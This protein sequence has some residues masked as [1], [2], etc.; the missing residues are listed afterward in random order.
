MI[1]DLTGLANRA[2][3]LQAIDRAIAVTRR[4][5][6]T[7]SLLY[8]DLDRF[9]RLND[10]CGHDAGDAALR[11]VASALSATARRT[12][13]VGR[14]GGDDF[15]VV[16]SGPR[17]AAEAVARR[18]RERIVLRLAAQGWLMNVSIGV[19]TFGAPPSSAEAALAE[20]DAALS[21]AKR[22]TEPP[23]LRWTTTAGRNGG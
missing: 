9:R 19:A 16:L 21:V 17:A 12:D 2:A 18:G 20:A 5:G 22:Q 10:R 15:V 7:V 3:V 14:I 4:G 8:I 13:T 6:P 1:D 23:N 11:E